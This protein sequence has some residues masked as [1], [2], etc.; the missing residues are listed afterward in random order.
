MAISEDKVILQIIV[1][2]KTKEFIDRY[3]QLFNL[4]VSYFCNLALCE[5]IISL[6]NKEVN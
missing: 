4:S 1:S 2:K 3:C 6:M 5:K